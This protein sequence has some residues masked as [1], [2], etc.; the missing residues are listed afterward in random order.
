MYFVVA[1]DRRVLNYNCTY[2]VRR[3]LDFSLFPEPRQVSRDRASLTP[4]GHSVLSFN[5][6]AS[7][8]L[9]RAPVTAQAAS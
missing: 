9:G 6:G 5:K 7:R 4:Q 2:R 1:N 8:A 3:V